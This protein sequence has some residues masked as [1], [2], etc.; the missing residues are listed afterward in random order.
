MGDFCPALTDDQWNRIRQ[1]V[2]D[3]ALRARVA[4]SFRMPPRIL[5]CRPRLQDACPMTCSGRFILRRT[6][7]FCPPTAFRSC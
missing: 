7:W 4:A 1:I 5:S 2:H 6:R 3:E